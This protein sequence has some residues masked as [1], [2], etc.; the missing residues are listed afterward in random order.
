MAMLAAEAEEALQRA[1]RRRGQQALPACKEA[2][3]SDQCLLSKY[4]TMRKKLAWVELCL[5]LVK[6]LS[7]VANL[8]AAIEAHWPEP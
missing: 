2:V 5:P 8:L 3:V 6:E 4:V 7:S 1:E